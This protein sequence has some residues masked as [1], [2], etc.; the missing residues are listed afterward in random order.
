MSEDFVDDERLGETRIAFDDVANAFFGWRAFDASNILLI[1]P[2][3]KQISV[4]RPGARRTVG[5][6]LD[7]FDNAIESPK[8]DLRAI[9]TV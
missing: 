3:L 2:L 9:G 8:I 4:S 5:C 7:E 6:R 1:S